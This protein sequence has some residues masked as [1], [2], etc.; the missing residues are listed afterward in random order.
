MLRRGGVGGNNWVVGIRTP[1][2][3]PCLPPLVFRVDVFSVHAMNTGSLGLRLLSYYVCLCCV[4]LCVDKG[5]LT[6]RTTVQNSTLLSSALPALLSSRVEQFSAR[7]YD[8]NGEKQR[9]GML[10][11]LEMLREKSVP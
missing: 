9:M 7:K 11:V 10:S 6:F 8:E 2:R 1:P 3:A 5:R 4:A